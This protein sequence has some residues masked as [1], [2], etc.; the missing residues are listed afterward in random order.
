[1]ELVLGVLTCETLTEGQLLLDLVVNEGFWVHIVGKTLYNFL[2]I[3]LSPRL[4]INKIIRLSHFKEIGRAMS[5]LEFP[6]SPQFHN[7]SILDDCNSITVLLGLLD[8][9][10]N[11]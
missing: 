2:S 3:H 8:A 4:S 9:L 10:C 5:Q 11:Y 7:F 1:M 6:R